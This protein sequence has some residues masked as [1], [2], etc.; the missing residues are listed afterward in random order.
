MDFTFAGLYV[1]CLDRHRAAA[2][3]RDRKCNVQAGALSAREDLVQMTGRKPDP[4]CKGSLRFSS[5]AEVRAKLFHSGKFAQCE[6]IVKEKCSLSAI[7]SLRG[8]MAMF[9]L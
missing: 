9:A 1:P 7:L 4:L 6:L 5:F 3:V 2:G 8:L